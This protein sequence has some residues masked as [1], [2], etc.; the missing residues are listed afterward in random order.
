MTNRDIHIGIGS[1]EQFGVDFIRTWRR[2]EKNMAGETQTEQVRFLNLATLLSTLTPKRLEILQV[3]QHQS[4]ATAYQ[5]AK[6][7][8]RHY[9]NVHTD[10]RLLRDI[11]LI[12]ADDT[13][14]GLRVPFTKIHAEIDL[15]A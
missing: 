5:L 1:M 11:G 2:G 13:G 8:G 14:A 7:L 6:C 12:E 4:G 10:V 3:L 9:K 15:A